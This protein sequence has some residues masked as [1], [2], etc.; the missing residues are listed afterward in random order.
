MITTTTIIIITTTTTTTM[1]IGLNTTKTDLKE[2]QDV[3]WIKLTQN[4]PLV[5]TVMNIWVL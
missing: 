3:D 2:C 1:H 5:S 4:R